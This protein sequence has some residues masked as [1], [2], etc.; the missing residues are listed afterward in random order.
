MA[1]AASVQRRSFA[2]VVV[3]P[4]TMGKHPRP[5]ASKHG[6]RVMTLARWGGAAIA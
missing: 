5:R 6:T 3:F 1:R 2:V 4:R